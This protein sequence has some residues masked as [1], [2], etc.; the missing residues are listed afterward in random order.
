MTSAVCV[1]VIV[2]IHLLTINVTMALCLL[3][4]V[5]LGLII[6]GAAM[7]ITGKQMPT[8]HRLLES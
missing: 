1:P 7:A 5:V 8:Y 3:V 2:F 6:Q 4:P